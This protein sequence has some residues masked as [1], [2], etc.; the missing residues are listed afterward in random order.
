MVDGVLELRKLKHPIVLF[1]C[2]CGKQLFVNLKDKRRK[3][4][5]LKWIREEKIDKVVLG[6]LDSVHNMKLYSFPV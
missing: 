2:V 1:L 4:K 3:R 5:V 6:E